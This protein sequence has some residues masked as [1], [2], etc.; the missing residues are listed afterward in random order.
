MPEGSIECRK[1]VGCVATFVNCWRG[2]SADFVRNWVL[3]FGI[4]D[5]AVVK[6]SLPPRV[7]D[8]RW[9]SLANGSNWILA[10]DFQKIRYVVNM[11]L[12]KSKVPTSKESLFCSDPDAAESVHLHRGKMG[13]WRQ[14]TH[15]IANSKHFRIVMMIAT[16]VHNVLLH[17]QKFLHKNNPA[18][19]LPEL[20]QSKDDECCLQFESLLRFDAW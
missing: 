18:G 16:P 13:R 3:A 20:V 6:K 14:R 1:Y 17:V 7:I 5:A 15:D 10:L 8:T 12:S 9:C 2:F 4:V 19:H 11:T